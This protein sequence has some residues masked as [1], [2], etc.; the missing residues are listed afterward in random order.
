M[1]KSHTIR[2]LMGPAET[3]RPFV[4]NSATQRASTTANVNLY[5]CRALVPGAVVQFLDYEG[6]HGSEAPVALVG[7]GAGA[8]G[9]G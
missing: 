8:G 1:G 5:A 6:E 9:G 3:E 4:Q 2:E 7:G